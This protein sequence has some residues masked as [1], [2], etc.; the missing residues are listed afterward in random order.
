MQE[1][2]LMDPE[3][4]AGTHHLVIPIYEYYLIFHVYVVTARDAAHGIASLCQLLPSE[5][6]IDN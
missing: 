3:F 2:L 1:T 6:G 4:L 5:P